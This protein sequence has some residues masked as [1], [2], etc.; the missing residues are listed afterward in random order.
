MKRLAIALAMGASMGMVA[1]AQSSS[2]DTFTVQG[3]VPVVCVATNNSVANPE[4][5][6]LSTTAQQTLG[7]FTY[8]CNSAAGFT[9][10][11]TSANGGT[12]NGG[13]QTIAYLFSH[14]GGSGLG[15]SPVSL[16]AP[17]ITNLSGS[18][19]FIA[20]QTGSVRVEVPG[21]TAG[22]FAGTYSDDITIAITAN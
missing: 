17:V 4:I 11:I 1:E 20:G 9:R 3:D 8:S 15:V 10:T 16:S 14:G 12:L 21:G 2:T 19:A 13:S 5:I 22:L 7:S 6:D 18:T